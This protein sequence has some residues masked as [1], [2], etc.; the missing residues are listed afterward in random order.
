MHLQLKAAKM[1]LISLTEGFIQPQ[2]FSILAST[3]MELIQTVEDSTSN[4]FVG[5]LGFILDLC[6]GDI[7][8]NIQ[9]IINIVLLKSEKFESVSTRLVCTRIIP[10]LLRY[11]ANVLLSNAQNAFFIRS[12]FIKTTPTQIINSIPPSFLKNTHISPNIANY[13]YSITHPLSTS[14]SFLLYDSP[15]PLVNGVPPPYF[16]LPSSFTTHLHGYPTFSY[17][18]SCLY[19]LPRAWASPSFVSSLPVASELFVTKMDS[20]SQSA[21][22][23]PS[24]KID[25]VNI[26]SMTLLFF[27]IIFFVYYFPF[28][29]IFYFFILFLFFIFFFFNDETRSTHAPTT[30]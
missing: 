26:L 9:T 5:V 3:I 10:K 4:A 23:N 7:I 20:P 24:E 28:Y 1:L 15:S 14:S 2:S 12:Q 19:P 21:N 13:S 25:L 11:I 18:S 30:F 29:Q 27:I 6:P 8:L 17:L 16:R 22:K